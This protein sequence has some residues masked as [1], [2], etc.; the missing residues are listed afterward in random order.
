MNDRGLL[1]SL[2]ALPACGP[3]VADV[4]D[5]RKPDGGEPENIE[6]SCKAAYAASYACYDDLGYGSSGGGYGGYGSSGSYDPSEYIDEICESFGQYADAYGPG[7]AGAFEEV[8]ACLASLDCSVLLARQESEASVPD[9]CQAVFLDANAR[10]PDGIPLCGERTISFAAA[11]EVSASLCA[12]GHSY[13]ARCSEPGATQ[14]CECDRNGEVVQTVTLPGELACGTPELFDE[15]SDACGFPPGVFLAQD[16]SQPETTSSTE[17]AHGPAPRG[18]DLEQ[19]SDA[20]YH[21][22]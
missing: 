21:R 5:P 11:C 7:C 22:A 12:D 8:F 14:S 18:P 4:D 19:L 15:L 3:S 17:S 1:L 2:L 9:P 16:S 6:S 20:D 10:C 13:S